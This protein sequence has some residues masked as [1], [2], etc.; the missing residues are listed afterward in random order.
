MYAEDAVDGVR[1]V[2]EGGVA[3]LVA[4]AG[5]EVRTGAAT[6][7]VA[8][9]LGFLCSFVP[10]NPGIKNIDLTPLFANVE[11]EVIKC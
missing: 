3:S 10:H 4:E 2:S 1:G 6:T 8:A 11:H 7:A 5:G 9:D